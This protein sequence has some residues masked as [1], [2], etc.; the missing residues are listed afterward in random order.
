MP[1][2]LTQRSCTFLPFMA[3]LP[4]GLS[5]ACLLDNA[6]PD[7]AGEPRALQSV[8]LRVHD[9]DAMVAFYEEAFGA[10]FREVDT[11]GI[12]SRFAEIDGLTI[13]FVPLRD[14]PD[15]E[16]YPSHQLGFEVASIEEVF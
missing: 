13:K 9:L 6:P 14:A 1:R 10:T 2:S 5:N 16:G 15:F 12:S 7:P 11:F 8:A 3:L 4:A